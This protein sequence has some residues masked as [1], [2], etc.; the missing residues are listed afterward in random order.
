M[1]E[2]EIEKIGKKIDLFF[3]ILLGLKIKP[4]GCLYNR[5]Y[6]D[7]YIDELTLVYDLSVEK[8]VIDNY[9]TQEE[10][11]SWEIR[12]IGELSKLKQ[13]YGEG[14]FLTKE[15]DAI[16]LRIRFLGNKLDQMSKLSKNKEKFDDKNIELYKTDLFIDLQKKLGITEEYDNYNYRKVIREKD[17]IKKNIQDLIEELS[18]FFSVE[19]ISRSVLEG[20]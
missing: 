2:T 1:I 10:I 18:K 16:K 19:T 5:K 15:Q 9:P 6:I 14:N 7:N 20:D 11:Q 13:D 12:L 4:I 17:N 8:D 3:K